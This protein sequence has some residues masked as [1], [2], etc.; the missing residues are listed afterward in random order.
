MDYITGRHH[1]TSPSS[2]STQSSSDKSEEL[3][4]PAAP[5]TLSMDNREGMYRRGVV[6]SLAV[7]AATEILAE[8]AHHQRKN[9]NK[10]TTT[11][12]TT[13]TTKGDKGDKGD[14]T[15]KGE[16]DNATTGDDSDDNSVIACIYGARAINS[17]L[18]EREQLF[19]EDVDV[20][21]YMGDGATADDFYSWCRIK[22]IEM[23]KR[24]EIHTINMQQQWKIQAEQLATRLSVTSTPTT[25]TTSTT[26]STTDTTTDTT[27][28][29]GTNTT[30]A[31]G[32]N[33]TTTTT[34]N[35]ST[36]GPMDMFE[37]RELE[38]TCDIAMDRGQTFRSF[39]W[40]RGALTSCSVHPPGGIQY[41]GDSLPSNVVMSAVKAEGGHSIRQFRSILQPHDVT[42]W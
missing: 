11:S 36:P 26:T 42:H 20:Q 1:Q 38:M 7:L 19:T 22:C 5:S 35:G 28:P 13:T 6:R 12:A 40:W 41:P 15:I 18:S 9:K 39:P 24:W 27:T 30:T 32:T 21:V 10:K 23:T 14:T 31:T 34:A 25:T 29:T 17:Y 33:T 16:D 4:S 37:R 8:C 3:I 2:P